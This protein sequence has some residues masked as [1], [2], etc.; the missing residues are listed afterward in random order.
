MSVVLP[1][2]DVLGIAAVAVA[3][4]DEIFNLD[5]CRSILYGV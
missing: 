3:R 5:Q 1:G 2:I 4:T